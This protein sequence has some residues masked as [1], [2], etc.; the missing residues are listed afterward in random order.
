MYFDINLHL[1]EY[2]FMSFKVH[3]ILDTCVYF[4]MCDLHFLKRIFIHFL[5]LRH[6]Y[7]LYA[8]KIIKKR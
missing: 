1:T 7:S 3:L 2:I 8:N 6:Y 4:C 5:V